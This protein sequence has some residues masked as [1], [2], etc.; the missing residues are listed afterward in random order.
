MPLL[1]GTVLWTFSKI[2]KSHLGV[3]KNDIISLIRLVSKRFFQMQDPVGIM[4]FQSMLSLSLLKG[5]KWQY[6]FS[7]SSSGIS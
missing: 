3:L 2:K 5:H 1:L 6:N 7:D 4:H